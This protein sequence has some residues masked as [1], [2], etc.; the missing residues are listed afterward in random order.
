LSD[1]ILSHRGI[2]ILIPG[3]NALFRGGS[4]LDL[5]QKRVLGEDIQPFRKGDQPPAPPIPPAA[6]QEQ[7]LQKGQPRRDEQLRPAKPLSLLMI[8]LR[9]HA[10]VFDRALQ[11][12]EQITK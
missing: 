7:M 5:E 1:S 12:I 3:R 8:R 4:A 2:A 10:A 9:H 11:M 6:A